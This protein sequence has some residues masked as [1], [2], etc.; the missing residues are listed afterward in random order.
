MYYNFSICLTSAPKEGKL[1]WKPFH[2]MSVDEVEPCAKVCLAYP[3]SKCQGFNYDYEGSGYCELLDIVQGQDEIRQV[4]VYKM[5]FLNVYKS[6]CL[7]E[8]M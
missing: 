4:S 6:R 5:L 2:T 8:K 3:P 7:L 1:V